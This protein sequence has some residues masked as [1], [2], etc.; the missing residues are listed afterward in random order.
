[1]GADY[2][3]RSVVRALD[4][5]IAVSE[6]GPAD[7]STIAR[8][9][10]LHPTTTLRMLESLRSR[11]LVRHRRGRYEIGARAFE[12]GSAFLNGIS[13]SAEAQLLVEELATRVNETANF[14]ILDQGE[15][16]YLAI[17]RSQWELGIQW[18]PGGRHPAHCTALGKAILAHMQWGDVAEILRDH[19]PVRMTPATLIEPDDIRRELNLVA[20]RGYAVDSEER[21]SGVVCVGAPIRDSK[22]SV[23]AAVSISGPAMRLSLNRL[24]V[25]AEHVMDIAE[26][27]SEILG[28]PPSRPAP[29]TLP[30]GKASIRSS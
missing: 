11:D 12:V 22:G 4:V 14:G 26:R 21:L 16:L 10:Q 13:L 7:L 27:G 1:M 23:V 24:P 30:S 28:A 17:A 9:V 6:H 25:V 18:L 19:P 2:Q 29:T 5:L 8:A 20:R 15:V 3:V